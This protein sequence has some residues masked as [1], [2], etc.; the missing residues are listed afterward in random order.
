M[1]KFY[2]T[3]PIYYVNTE[4]HLGH[5][6]TT[7]FADSIA[8]Y[9]RLNGK[10]VY[11]LTGSDEHGAK[12]LRSAE[13]AGIEVKKFVDE[14]SA[15]FKNLFKALN[16][17]NDDFIRTSD[18]V[19]HFRAAQKLW[20]KLEEAGDIYKANYKGLYCVGCEAFITEK[21][22]SEGKCKD[23]NKEP[24]IINEENYFFRLSRYSD[25]IKVKIESGEMKIIP[26]TRK[27]EILSLLRDGLTDISFSRPAKDISWG[28]PVPNDA[29]QTMY[30]WCDALT[31]YISALGYGGK[32]DS[33]FQKFWPADLHIIGKDILRFHA[34]IWPA[35]LISAKLPLPKTLFAH[36]FITLEGKK[37]SKTLGNVINPADLIKE[38]GTDSVRYYFLSQISLTDDG[39]FSVQRLHE[40]YNGNLANGIGNLV[41][42]TAKMALQYFGGKITKPLEEMTVSVPFTQE[43]NSLKEF[44]N[45]KEESVEFF[46]I[47]Y[48]AENFILPRYKELMEN[49]EINKAIDLLWLFISEFDKYIDSYKPFILIKTDKE[50]TEAVL[51]STLFGLGFFAVLLAPFLPETAEKIFKILGKNSLADLKLNNNFIEELKNT[52][53]DFEIQ[54][55]LLSPLFLRKD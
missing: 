18:Q 28:V 35:M 41:Q 36:G 33:N 17:S 44:K 40:I 54:E 31:N 11:F 23:H 19:R 43:L 13:A 5:A 30:V 15:K 16:I 53:R 9:E 8:R 38:F 21:D 51:W 48:T 46:S 39:D 1:Q 29:T 49:F 7:I 47:P 2:I 20:K 34:A 12:I 50:K 26:E 3:T 25:E 4:L 14:N 24:E 27:N 55:S 37:M 32:D 45:G 52:L 42:R 6:F 22:L 10:E